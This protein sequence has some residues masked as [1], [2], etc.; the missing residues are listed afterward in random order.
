MF[1]ILINWVKLMIKKFKKQK[2]IQCL[3]LPKDPQSFCLYV[4]KAKKISS[5]FFKNKN[6]YK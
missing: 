2:K 6:Y 5:E 1:Q 3:G 4:V